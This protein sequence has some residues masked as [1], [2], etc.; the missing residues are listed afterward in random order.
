[1]ALPLK[2][3]LGDLRSELITRLGFGAQGA[4]AGAIIQIVDSILNRE[5][6]YLYW[7]YNFN[8]LQ[9]TAEINTAISQTLYDWPDDVNPRQTWEY[10]VQYNDIWHP[11]FENI[12]FEYDTIADMPFFPRRYDK[13]DQLE[14]WPQPDA[15]YKIRYEYYVRLGRF[16]QDTDRCTVDDDL[17]FALAL[18]KA[19]LHYRHPDAQTYLAQADALMRE[20]NLRN[21]GQ[22]RFIIGDKDD[23][24]LPRPQVIDY[25]P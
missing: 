2:P 16:T 10:R 13:K 19:K 17:L 11:M 4:A 5:Q 14:I 8:E 22:K 12:T 21:L 24:A 3:T 20:L 15:V 7:K 18:G 25:P 6:Q 1:M 9:K 23:E